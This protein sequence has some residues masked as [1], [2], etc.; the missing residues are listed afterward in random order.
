MG[1]FGPFVTSFGVFLPQLQPVA[2]NLRSK[3][4]GVHG[5]RVTSTIGAS[6]PSVERIHGIRYP[7][8]SILNH[9]FAA[10]PLA[11]FALEARAL[12]NLKRRADG[13]R[14]L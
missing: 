4:F 3:L 9:Q 5:V 2:R 11:R 1:P 10:L 8:R 13:Q 14:W 7:K 6:R 12:G